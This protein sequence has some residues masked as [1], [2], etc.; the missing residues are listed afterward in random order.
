MIT[1][2]DILYKDVDKMWCCKVC[3]KRIKHKSQ[4][5]KTDKHNSNLL[6]QQK[7]ESDKEKRDDYLN[8][9]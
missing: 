2:N 9:I 8:N 1:N 4:H 6:N 5:T 3:K 7:V